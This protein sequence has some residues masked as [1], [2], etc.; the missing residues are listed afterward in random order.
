MTPYEQACAA[1]ELLQQRQDVL[2]RADFELLYATV[3]A[4]VVRESDLFG[5]DGK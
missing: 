3:T 1:F 5:E 2:P 4:P